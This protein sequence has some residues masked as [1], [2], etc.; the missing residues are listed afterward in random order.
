MLIHTLIHIPYTSFVHIASERSNVPDLSPTFPIV[1][2]N[3][4]VIEALDYT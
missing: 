3:I 4:G 2:F 1:V